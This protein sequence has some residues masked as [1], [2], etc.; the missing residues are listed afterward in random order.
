[1]VQWRKLCLPM[2]KTQETQV[3]SLGWEDPLEKERATQ[4]STLSWKIPWTEEPGRLHYS[5]WVISHQESDTTEQLHF[6]F[7]FFIRVAPELG[8][9]SVISRRQR[10]LVASLGPT[11]RTPA[12]PRKSGGRCLLSADR[13]ETWPAAALIRRIGW[14]RVRHD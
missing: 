1:M 7:S 6:L 13:G 9:I 5:P 10:P 3:Q 4:C 2:Q 12:L 8:K 11:R 14:Q